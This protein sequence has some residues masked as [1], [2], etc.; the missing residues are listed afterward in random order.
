M[1]LPNSDW[2][3]FLRLQKSTLEDLNRAQNFVRLYVYAD[4]EKQLTHHE[5]LIA[6]YKKYGKIFRET[7]AGAEAVHL[8][9]P[10][11]SQEVYMHEGKVCMVHAAMH[12]TSVLDYE[13][14]MH[15][16]LYR[17]CIGTTHTSA[18]QYN[19]GIPQVTSHVTRAG[20]HV[21][22]YNVIIRRH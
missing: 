12:D 4:K 10:Q 21:R 7:F 6:M 8:F 14:D 3:L 17:V 9:D 20:K 18:A 19:T 22:E 13:Q 1:L 5:E 2:L 11:Y 15:V 16:A